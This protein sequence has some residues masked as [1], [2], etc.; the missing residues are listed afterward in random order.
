[1]LSK[2][3]FAIQKALIGIGGE[4]KSV[5][6]LRSGDLLIETLSALQTKSF[7]LAKTFLNASVTISPHKT[8]NSCCSVISKPDLLT[9]PEAEILE[10][11]S[12]QGVIQVA[13]TSTSTATATTQTD[14]TITKI[15]C[16]T[17][18]LLQPLISIPKATIS[19]SVPA[20]TKSSTSTQAQLLPS[21]SSVTVT[22]PSESPPP[23]SLMD[24]AAAISNSLSLIHIINVHTPYQ[25]VLFL[26]PQPLHSIPYLLHPR[27]QKKL[28]NLE[29]KKR[30]PKNTCDTIKPKIEIKM[31]PHKPRKP[32]PIE[33][34]MD[35]EDM[36]VYDV[37]DEPEPNP[38]YV[39]NMRGY[40]YKGELVNKPNHTFIRHDFEN[41]IKKPY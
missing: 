40:T 33:Y 14:E 12:N 15:V 18:K 3:P 30:P 41:P 2:S 21:T 29:G 7:L 31:A 36:I 19:S 22:W 28:Q 16:P 38:K 5:K 13:K 10:G 6:R 20:V 26:K 32:A 39:L 11:F 37:E 35:E 27:M 23:I 4:P 9:T 25:H 1:M 24:T 17:L 8:L 34:T